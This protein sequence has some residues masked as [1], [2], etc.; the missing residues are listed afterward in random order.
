MCYEKYYKALLNVI[1]ATLFTAVIHSLQSLAV[2]GIFSDDLHHSL[3]HVDWQIM[4]YQHFTAHLFF[5]HH[6]G[7]IGVRTFA[8]V[9]LVVLFVVRM[10]SMVAFE[11]ILAPDVVSFMF[12]MASFFFLGEMTLYVVAAFL[13]DF[14]LVKKLI[15]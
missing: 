15:I 14:N 10:A 13:C 8:I 7:V 2:L 6:S 5:L 4:V 11:L 1:L 3:M 9:T 12:S